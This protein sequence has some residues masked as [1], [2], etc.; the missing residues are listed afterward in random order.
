MSV[1]ISHSFENKP[2]FDNIAD[3]LSQNNVEYWNPEEV[4]PG[5]SLRDQLRRA[6]KDCSVC[7]FIATRQALESSWCGAELGA[8]W[9]AGKPIIVYLAE[10]S[11]KEIELPPIVQGDVWEERIKRVV[12][13]A[14]ELA[15]LATAA[16][17]LTT[18]GRNGP[19][20][21]GEMTA[22]QLE[23][24]IVGAI[25]LAAATGKESNEVTYEKI[26]LAAK[27]A[28]A[29]LADGLRESQQVTDASG[30]D[31]RKRILW[32]D[33][34]PDNNIYERQAF[35]ALGIRFTLALSTKEALELLSKERFG[36]IL[37]DMGRVEGPREG[38]VLLDAI[39]S[40]GDQTPFF[41]YAGSNS[42]RH[43]REAE[44]HS[45]Q[46]STN[47]PQELFGMVMQVLR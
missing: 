39:R 10:P 14:G 24:I 43:K 11:L 35:E 19:T 9:G 28:A 18:E 25:S 40:L 17:T 3:A 41:I 30:T 45:A 44:A 32:V 5:S 6:V 23:R 15:T 31:S 37:S 8:F 29:S 2:Q 16:A 1:F 7:V 33:D 38:Y 34:R 12:A 4:K 20:I 36:A 22:E 13:R 42:T 26:G 27:R 21:V 47:N 46:G